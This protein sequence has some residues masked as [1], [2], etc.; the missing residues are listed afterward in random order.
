M[1]FD[2]N[3]TL[4]DMLQNIREVA[5]D[6]WDDIKTVTGQMLENKKIRLEIYARFRLEGKITQEEFE[7]RLED[8]KLITESELHAVAVMKKATA[9]KIA[10]A[11]IETLN[12]AVKAVLD[13]A[14]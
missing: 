2:I 13:S 6:Q 9:Q 12:K 1:Q 3:E 10:N 8:E 11:M 5:E 7:Q 14:L 4:A